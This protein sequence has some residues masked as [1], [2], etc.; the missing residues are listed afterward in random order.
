[1]LAAAIRGGAQ[2]IITANAKD[3]PAAALAPLGLGGSPPRRLPPR[4]ARPQPAHH[5]AGYPRA[6]RPHPET[7]AHPAR[8]GDPPRPG[9]RARV[10]RRAPPPHGQP[11]PRHLTGA[12]RPNRVS[13]PADTSRLADGGRTARRC[14]LTGRLAARTGCCQ[15]K[16]PSV[17]TSAT[18]TLMV[19]NMSHRAGSCTS[20][21]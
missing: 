5:P 16:L 3:F 10:R 21:R 1:M 18:Q 20:H 11:P 9:R 17:M 15:Q 13:L 8:P 7:T 6:G 19:D 4:P 14:S 12:G 2:A